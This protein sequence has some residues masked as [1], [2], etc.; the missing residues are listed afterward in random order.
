M[1]SAGPWSGLALARLELDLG[2][3][4]SARHDVQLPLRSFPDRDRPQRQHAK[5][6]AIHQAV[7]EDGPFH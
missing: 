2:G 6:D 5:K 3:M 1:A 7:T 4:G